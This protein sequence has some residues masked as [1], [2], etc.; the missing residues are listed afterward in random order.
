MKDGEEVP[1]DEDRITASFVSRAY[2]ETMQLA[3]SSARY[4]KTHGAVDRTRLD[5]VARA[6]FAAES[7]RLTARLGQ[8]VSWHLVQRSVE[9]GELSVEE[10]LAP[11][12]RLGAEEVC[13]VKDD[14]VLRWLPVD[15][16]ELLEKSLEQYRRA[17]HLQSIMLRNR[18][19]GS[20][21]PLDVLKDRL[22]G[23][24]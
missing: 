3:R 21:H 24:K 20:A 5:S 1:A 7:L 23:V 13:L 4:F 2:D 19:E 22:T 9:S 12:R 10:A 11:E 15:L 6:A 14:E 8:L 17:L 18:S 16:R